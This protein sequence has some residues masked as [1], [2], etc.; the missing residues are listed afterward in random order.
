[1]SEDAPKAPVSLVSSF[2][3][4]DYKHHEFLP[5]TDP[6]NPSERSSAM[7]TLR[8]CM[9]IARLTDYALLESHTGITVS[10]K[11]DADL[12]RFAIA[13]LED[14]EIQAYYFTAHPDYSTRSLRYR[15]RK[16]QEIAETSGF[17]G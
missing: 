6:Y 3:A 14:M 15:M 17:S 1:M 4:S 10:L 12:S 11:N 2:H 7:S 16:L 8:G 5:F 9:Q 13:R